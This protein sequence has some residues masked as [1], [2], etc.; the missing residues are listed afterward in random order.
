MQSK[1]KIGDLVEVGQAYRGNGRYS[2]DGWEGLHTVVRV[3]SDG[4]YRL[5]RGDHSKNPEERLYCVTIYED[6][7]APGR[8]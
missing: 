2:N 4:F 8:D 6:R 1:F 7:L 3:C 5:A